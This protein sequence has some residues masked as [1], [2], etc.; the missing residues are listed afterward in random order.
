MVLNECALYAYRAGELHMKDLYF[1]L[2]A[3][4]EVY[5]RPCGRRSQASR[6]AP[7]G[8]VQSSCE[9]SLISKPTRAPIA[10]PLLQ[11]EVSVGNTPLPSCDEAQDSSSYAVLAR[12]DARLLWQVHASKPTTLSQGNVW[13]SDMTT[14]VCFRLV[15]HSQNAILVKW[16]WGFEI[17]ASPT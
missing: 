17:L 11:R 15:R 6:L 12:S 8:V 3:C 2:Q 14:P 16:K 9:C 1:L 10:L 5:A 13:N 7:I 4:C